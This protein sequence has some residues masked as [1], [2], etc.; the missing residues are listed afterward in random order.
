MQSP[1]TLGVL[2]LTLVSLSGC[3]TIFGGT[4]QNV[5]MYSTPEGAEVII[6]GESVGT[7]PVAFEMKRGK[8][9]VVEFRREGYE[10][11]R[12]VLNRK[13]RVTPLVFNI[14]SPFYV[15]LAVDFSNGAAY[16][17]DPGFLDVELPPAGGADDIGMV[18][19][20][21][22]DSSASPTSSH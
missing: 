2:V 3:G 4:Y 12:V 16:Y 20:A 22:S 7:T 19:V 6:N 1:R 14:F 15:G 21:P 9:Y 11:V 13:V 18:F 8:I 17:V 10:D 5:P